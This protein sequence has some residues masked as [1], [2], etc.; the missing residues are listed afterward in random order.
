MP[1]LTPLWPIGL[2]LAEIYAKCANAAGIAHDFRRCRDEYEMYG[3]APSDKNPAHDIGDLGACRAG[4]EAEHQF[5]L[6]C[7]NLWVPRPCKV[8]PGAQRIVSFQQI[9]SET[10]RHMG[11]ENPVGIAYFGVLVFFVSSESANTFLQPDAERIRGEN[12][13]SISLRAWKWASKGNV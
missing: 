10:V 13:S 12:A 8:H 6:S 11:C 3:K 4:V 1:N 9:A 2:W 5:H 7:G